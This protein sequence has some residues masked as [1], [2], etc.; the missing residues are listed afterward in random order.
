[1]HSCHGIQ[2]SP[3]GNLYA[4][5]IYQ[6][7]YTIA[8]MHYLTAGCMTTPC[9]S[10]RCPATTAC[11]YVDNFDEYDG[12]GTACDAYVRLQLLTAESGTLQN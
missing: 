5:H 10:T 3:E 6:N 2:Q 8:A 4:L 12:V 1:M 9:Y 11:M 7:K